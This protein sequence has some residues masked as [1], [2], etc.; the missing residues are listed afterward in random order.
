MK[1]KPRHIF[2][3][4]KKKSMS[5]HS[6]HSSFPWSI[7]YSRFDFMES[8]PKTVR[9]IANNSRKVLIDQRVTLRGDI[10]H[11]GMPNDDAF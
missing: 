11:T 6:F 1:K 9:F 10:E 4:K 7:F 5:L 3:L 2:F 8:V